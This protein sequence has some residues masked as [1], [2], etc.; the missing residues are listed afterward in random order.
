M[1]TTEQI[2][3]RIE[4]LTAERDQYMALAPNEIDVRLQMMADQMHAEVSMR[5]QSFNDRIADLE[6]LRDEMEE[7]VEVGEIG[8]IGDQEYDENLSD[9]GGN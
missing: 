2:Q 9:D 4:K 7:P 8:E 5:L 6:A 1:I 3:Q